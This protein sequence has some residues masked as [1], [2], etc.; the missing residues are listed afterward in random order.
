M[1]SRLKIVIEL[2]HSPGELALA[3]HS[4]T[5]EGFPYATSIH[6]AVDEHHR[7]VLLLSGLAEHTKC[8]LADPR[9]GIVVAHPL[10]DGEIARAS[11][12]GTVQP[13]DAGA[14]LVSRYLRFNPAAERFLQFGDFRFHRFDP[15]RIRVVGGFAQAGWLDGKALM[16]APHVS[17]DDEA[18]ILAKAQDACPSG[19]TLLGFDAYGVD[20]ARDG[21]R[22]RIT[23]GAGPVPAD[24]L[25]AAFDRVLRRF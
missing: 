24:A 13:I 15:I 20:F 2:L 4:V 16:D 18:R 9:A 11:L 6:Y 25:G 3:T 14:T 21:I 17:L 1:P 10:G 22:A 12:I 8:V 19:M 5:A 7:P 23:F